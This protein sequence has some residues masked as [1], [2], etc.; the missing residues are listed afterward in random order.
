[1]IAGEFS[2]KMC[3]HDFAWAFLRRNPD[4]RV[5]WERYGKGAEILI[6]D[7]PICIYRRYPVDWRAKR[8][9]LWGYVDPALPYDEAMPFWSASLMLE[10]EVVPGGERPVLELLKGAAAVMGLQMEDGALILKIQRASS[11]VH[12][13]I[14]DGRNFDHRA[15]LVLRLPVEPGLAAG[16]GQ[17]HTLWSLA[18]AA[19]AKCQEK[20][21]GKVAYFATYGTVAHPRRPF[22]AKNATRH[23]HR[24]LRTRR[25]RWRMV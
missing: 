7:R 1:M 21:W 5:D 4:Y 6:D 11:V 12:L 8:W 19:P 3:A 24:A 22:V 15:G 2:D 10:A 18:F 9:G 17:A 20:K 13:H 14:P 23:R 25:S 16:L